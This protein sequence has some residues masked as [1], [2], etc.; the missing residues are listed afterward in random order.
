MQKKSIAREARH[1]RFNYVFRLLLLLLLLLLLRNV[2]F[3]VIYEAEHTTLH[4]NFRAQ[5]FLALSTFGFLFREE[6]RRRYRPAIVGS[7]VRHAFFAQQKD[8]FES[9]EH[10]VSVLSLLPTG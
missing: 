4:T 10:P 1:A 7:I 9:D 2:A 6:F 5:R 3:L 8:H